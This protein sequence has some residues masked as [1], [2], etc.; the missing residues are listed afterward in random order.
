MKRKCSCCNISI[1]L[2]P[3]G[4]NNRMG[5]KITFNGETFIGWDRFGAYLGY[6][7]TTALNR[8]RDGECFLAKKQPGKVSTP[9]DGVGVTGLMRGW[10]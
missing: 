4:G 7:A 8:F 9:H 2:Q 1:T 6:S 10:S 5:A 3:N